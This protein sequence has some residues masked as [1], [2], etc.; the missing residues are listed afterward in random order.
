MTAV[1]Q[2]LKFQRAG[3]VGAGGILILGAAVIAAIYFISAPLA[4]LFFAAFRGPE[5]FLPFEDGA[6]WTFQNFTDVYSDVVLYT[7]IIPTTLIFV[8]GAVIVAFTIAFI[9]AWLIERTDLPGRN[10]F[11]TLTL[12]PVLIPTV[13][14]AIAWMFMFTPN[15]GWVNVALRAAFGLKT[16]S[17]PI[18]ILSMPGL[19]L[20]QGAALVPFTFLLLTAALKT[21]NSSLEEASA[22]SGAS[23]LTTFRR[24]TL[25]I[26]KPGIL[27][28]V[29]L[30]ALV[31][32]ES[33]ELPLII[34]LPARINVFAIRIFFELNPDSDLPVYGRAAAIALPFLA[35]ALGL[36][37]VYNYL[38]KRAESFVTITG[39]G[40]RPARYN[41]GRWK[42]PSIIFASSYV[43]LAAIIPI[44]VLIWVS[45]MGFE[46]PSFAALSKIS[47]SAYTDLLKDS[48]FYHAVVNTFVVAG[49]SAC[50]VTTVGALISWVIVRS[51]MPGKRLLDFLSFVSIGIPSIIAGLAMLLL[52]ISMPI[53]VYG[54]IWVL[55]LA[56]C[57]RLA[58]TT[59]ISRAGLMQ[60]HAELEEASQISGGQWWTTLRRVVLPLMAPSLFASF[61]LLFIIGFREFTLA[62]ILLSD[63]NMVLSVILFRFFENAEMAKAAAVAM[64][65]VILVVPVI[66]LARRFALP[67]ER[68]RG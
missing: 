23:P 68:T 50:I 52:Y 54:T 15:T 62:L 2:M 42:W 59:R 22:A 60:L 11:F 9:L 47:F 55:V 57:Y 39:K 16:S 13:I 36:L 4:M 7:E 34:G 27:A 44:L 26:L 28:P 6:E 45:L 61:I 67:Q 37:L 43:A 8:F 3:D 49:L 18:N 32:L 21:M 63:S 66:F 24:V 40:Y 58:V 64:L 12:F 53:G 33:F 14:L 29:I 30:G 51:N 38:I 31:V 41:L 19:I 46:P 65:I 5:D 56:Y 1:N 10:L 25:P 48:Q 17:G 35:A 20:A